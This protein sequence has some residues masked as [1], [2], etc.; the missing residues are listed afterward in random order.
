MRAIKIIFAVLAA[1]IAFP[2]I[3]IGVAIGVVVA[4]A[5]AVVR[6]AP[7]ATVSTKSI[8]RT[9]PD[10]KA[11]PDVKIVNFNKFPF[12]REDKGGTA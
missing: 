1:T 2:F 3:L 4:S 10:A 11:D 5:K 6:A 8:S 12:G 9:S 7:K